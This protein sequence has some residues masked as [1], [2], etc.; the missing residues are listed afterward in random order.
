MIK[1]NL[2]NISLRDAEKAIF[3]EYVCDNCKSGSSHGWPK[4]DEACFYCDGRAE[5]FRY[6]EKRFLSQYRL[7][8]PTQVSLGD[9]HRKI[10]YFAPRADTA[11]FI[12]LPAPSDG[13]TYGSI[14]SASPM[15][16]LSCVDLRDGDHHKASLAA[17]DI[18]SAF[19]DIPNDASSRFESLVNDWHLEVVQIRDDN[20]Y[21]Y[22]ED[23]Q[24][25]YSHRH[26][27]PSR[28]QPSW[29]LLHEAIDLY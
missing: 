19:F 8:M 9:C 13:N 27:D 5:Y 26:I 12:A 3:S 23:R 18:V 15:S 4:Q 20:G 14:G 6:M 24:Q 22:S 1:D 11:A 25:P 16:S 29:R 7:E 2:V 17:I 10:K 28:V 21:V